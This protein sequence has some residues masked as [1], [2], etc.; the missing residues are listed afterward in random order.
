MK[1]NVKLNLPAIR[2]LVSKICQFNLDQNTVFDTV[3][4]VFV[5]ESSTDPEDSRVFLLEDNK[6]KEAHEEFK[7]FIESLESDLK[8]TLIALLWVGRKD[9]VVEA[10][11]LAFKN[12]KEYCSNEKTASYLLS[13]PKFS[14]YLKRGL[15][16]LDVEA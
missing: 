16:Q 12:A 7:A 1:T 8:Q 14:Y 11:D 3:D 2:I 10:W 15:S 6:K 13:L 4:K 9:Y 5:S